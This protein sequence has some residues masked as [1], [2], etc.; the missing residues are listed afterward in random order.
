MTLDD[1]ILSVIARL[2][3]REKIEGSPVSEGT[4]FLVDYEGLVLTAGHA[5]TLPG[6]GV[7]P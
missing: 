7:R 1:S 4:A 2:E 5:V 3:V 6:E